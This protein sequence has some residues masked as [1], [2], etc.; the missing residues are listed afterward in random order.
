[1]T[2]RVG[3]AIRIHDRASVD[4]ARRAADRLDEG[5]AGPQKPFLVGVEN[6]HER[7]LRKIEALAQQVDADE[8]VELAPAQVAQDLDPFE[9]IDVGVQVADLDAELLVVPGSGLRPCAW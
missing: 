2:H 1:M 8:H 7:H 6:R 5:S 4:V 9:R 3:H